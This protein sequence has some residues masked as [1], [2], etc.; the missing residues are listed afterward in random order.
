MIR[1]NAFRL[2]TTTK[3][4]GPDSHVWAYWLIAWKSLFS[5]VLLRFED[6][7]R[8][9]YHTH[10]FNCVSWVLRGWLI[11]SVFGRGKPIH[12]H[13]SWRPVFTR[14]NTMHRVS[15]VGRTWV[16]SFRGPWAETWKDLDTKTGTVRLL[17]HGRR[18]VSELK[19]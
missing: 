12:Y 4:G 16:L 13:G 18:V 10:A 2:L 5:V 6:G 7:S 11:E 1:T 17:T 8:E 19:L 15:S 9:A 14:R 3:D